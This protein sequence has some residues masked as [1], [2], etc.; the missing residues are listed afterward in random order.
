[1]ALLVPDIGEL[2]SLRYLINAN[3]HVPDREDNAPRDLVLET[4]VS[5]TTPAEGDYPS[6]SAYYEPYNA[7]GTLGYGTAAITGYPDCINNRTET[8]RDYT[9]Q[10]GILLNGSSLVHHYNLWNYHCLSRTNFYLLGSCW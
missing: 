3:N 9:D 1:M 5:N 8:R 10:T 6:Q 2:E 4:Y 7:S